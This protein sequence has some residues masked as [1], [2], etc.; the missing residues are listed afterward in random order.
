LTR[1]HPRLPD[2]MLNRCMFKPVPS[3]DSP[4][5]KKAVL[6][7]NALSANPSGDELDVMVQSA[8]VEGALDFMGWQH[9]RVFCD[10]N[11]ELMLDNLEQDPPD[12]VFNLVES[13]GSKGALIH[14]PAWLLET[15]RIPFTGSPARTLVITTD[16]IWTKRILRERG[17]PT[18]DWFPLQDSRNRIVSGSRAGTGEKVVTGRDDTVPDRSKN[19]IL[20]PILEDGSAGITD[21]SVV[22]GGS[23]DPGVLLPNHGDHFLEEYIDGREFNITLLESREGV[24]VMPPAEMHFVDYPE[25]KPRIL[26][27][28]SKWEP[29]SFE[30]EKTIRSFDLPA[31][32]TGLTRLMSDISMNCWEIFGLK[33]Y[34]RVDFRVDGHGDPYVLEVNANPCISPDAGFTAA[35][36]RGGMNYIAMIERIMQA[37]TIQFQ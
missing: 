15:F 24:Q 6:L 21:E 1:S 12:L 35:C 32:D 34:A 37:A 5:M 9:R 36:A 8:A 14:L 18:P 22:D 28:A 27:F 16:K 2:A 33:G 7:I 30:Y 29:D 31:E 20:K 23:I 11:L 3:R 17:I 4:P 19:Y 26:N 25:S 13:L 10:L